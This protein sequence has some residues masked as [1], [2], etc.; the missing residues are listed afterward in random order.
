MKNSK[1]ENGE[2]DQKIRFLMKINSSNYDFQNKVC[3]FSGTKH[4]E[5][6]SSKR[7]N[8]VRISGYKND[9]ASVMFVIRN[10]EHQRFLTL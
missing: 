1:A 5:N 3:V 7:V 9:E 8:I 10:A 6:R 4:P 2:M